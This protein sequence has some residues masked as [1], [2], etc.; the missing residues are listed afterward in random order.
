MPTLGSDNYENGCEADYFSF[1]RAKETDFLSDASR[2]C[3]A[4]NFE[5]HPMFVNALCCGVRNFSIALRIL[6]LTSFSWHEYLSFL[7]TFVFCCYCVLFQLK[8]LS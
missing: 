5:V 4:T 6:F 8:C 3:L 7:C 2:Q 1:F